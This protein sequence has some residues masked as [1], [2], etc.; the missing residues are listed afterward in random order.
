MYSDML[1]ISHI[2]NTAALPFTADPIL[3]GFGVTNV[4]YIAPP[5]RPLA[6]LVYEAVRH[7]TGKIYSG[8]C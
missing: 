3:F 7:V 8:N 5:A 4:S 2:F 1:S 6:A